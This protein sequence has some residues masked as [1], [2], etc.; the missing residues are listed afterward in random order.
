[1]PTKSHIRE[2]TVQDAPALVAIYSYY[3]EHTSVSFEEQ[4][5][6]VEVFADRMV[7]TMKELPWLVAEVDG[8]IAGYA[9]AAPHR[10]RA[11]YRWTKEVSV[12]L[13]ADH[14][15]RGIARQLYTA[16]FEL[17]RKQGV[18]TLEA[19]I[20]MPNPASEAFHQSMGFQLVGTYH[21]VGYKAGQWHDVSWFERSIGDG[22]APPEQLLPWR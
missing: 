18:Q 16:L 9:Y 20:T 10:W 13:S 5:P 2:A 22:E 1:M 17:L 8:T 6:S 7:S 12:Y 4:V 19:G 11:A 3:I 14:H 21:N 15:R